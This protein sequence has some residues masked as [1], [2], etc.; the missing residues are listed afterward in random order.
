MCEVPRSGR[1]ESKWDLEIHHDET[2]FA[3]GGGHNISN[4]RL[5]CAAHNKLEAELPQNYSVRGAAKRPER[6]YGKNHMDK[7]TRKLE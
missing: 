1:C 3:M 2:P 4:L 5:L 6:V 7:F